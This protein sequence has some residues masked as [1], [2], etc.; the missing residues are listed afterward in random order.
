MPAA[1]IHFPCCSP[2]A[3]LARVL[4]PLFAD[5]SA[6]C[7]T[8]RCCGVARSDAVTR[9][10]ASGWARSA[11]RCADSLSLCG[12]LRALCAGVLPTEDGSS[13]LLLRTSSPVM[14]SAAMYVSSTPWSDSS[15]LEGD[16][17]A[18]PLSRC[19][20]TPG[21]SP[22]TYRRSGTGAL[23]EGEGWRRKEEDEEEGIKDLKRYARLAVVWDLH[24]SLVP[25]ASTEEKRCNEMHMQKS[26]TRSTQS[27]KG[28]HAWRGTSR[29]RDLEALTARPPAMRPPLPFPPMFESN[30]RARQ[31]AC[32]RKSHD[33]PKL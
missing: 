10:C 26:C 15:A 30:S 16:P 23:H 33:K 1:A 14:P 19:S 13:T 21:A 8:F 22:Y 28:G 32:F 18:A 17:C 31:P 5:T 4:L 3:P 20:A 6:A 29:R 25:R 11:A 27:T 9:A 12:E 7:W 2:C 24:G